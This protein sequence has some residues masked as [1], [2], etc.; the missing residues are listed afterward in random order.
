M[1]CG[2]GGTARQQDTDGRMDAVRSCQE[3]A[4]LV[5]ESCGTVQ[6]GRVDGQTGSYGQGDSVQWQQFGYYHD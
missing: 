1:G 5:I 6:G 4:D 3:W 2:W